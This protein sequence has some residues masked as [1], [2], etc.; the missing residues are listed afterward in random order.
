MKTCVSKILITMLALCLVVI[1]LPTI[2]HAAPMKLTYA[3]F[4]PGVYFPLRFRWNAGP[5]R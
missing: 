3:N 4:P 1:V 2:T 5:K